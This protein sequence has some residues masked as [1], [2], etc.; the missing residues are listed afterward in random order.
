MVGAP[1]QDTN[2]NAQNSHE[3]SDQTQPETTQSLGVSDTPESKPSLADKIPSLKKLIIMPVAIIVLLIVAGTS[4]YVY[5]FIL[6]QNESVVVQ[7]EGPPTEEESQNQVPTKPEEPTKWET[8][9]SQEYTF[10]F[11]YPEGQDVVIFDPFNLEPVSFSVIAIGPEQ[12][13]KPVVENKELLDGYIFRVIVHKN[14]I[15][16]DISDLTQKKHDSYFLNC[17][18]RSRISDIEYR[19][20]SG[21]ESQ[22][23]SVEN[24][25]QDYRETFVLREATVYEIVQV[26]QGNLGYKQVYQSIT[27]QMRESF[28]FTNLKGPTAPDQW[29]QVTDITAGYRLSHPNLDT[30]CCNLPNL[31]FGDNEKEAVF[32]DPETVIEG[33]DKPFD[34]FAVFTSDLDPGETY[35]NYL[36]QM[37]QA[38]TEEYRI[39]TGKNPTNT[40]EED[41]TVDGRPAK[42]LR[43]YLWYGNGEVVIIDHPDPERI[44][45]LTKTEAT[46]NSFDETFSQIVDSI[47]LFTDAGELRQREEQL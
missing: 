19:N 30:G 21:F 17:P 12:T 25:G 40:E 33:S 15:N 31:P 38:L 16:R 37:K 35:E 13:T 23:F 43:G 8:F 20:I 46:E 39:I 9:T 42:V 24:C 5:N 2:E 41:I 4:Y 26:Y 44:T 10:S 34:G 11:K 14:I 3:N 6:R 28:Q 1:P 36:T 27:D 18:G 7:Q 32:A 47:V 45:V 29:I 22:I